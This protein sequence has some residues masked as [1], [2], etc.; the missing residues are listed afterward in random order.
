[1]ILRTVLYVQVTVHRDKPR[2]NNQLDA[3]NI[4]N[5][6]CHETLHFLGIFCAHHQKLAAVP[7]AIG[8]FHAGYVAAS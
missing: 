8:M 1:M 3:T 4:Q 6:F 2:I 5:V 7:L